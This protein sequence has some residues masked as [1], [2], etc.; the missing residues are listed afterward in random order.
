MY[1]AAKEEEGK[2]HKSF[3]FSSDFFAA[4][5]AVLQLFISPFFDIFLSLCLFLL[6]P[7]RT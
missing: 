1:I 2:L 4:L 3:F 6:L 5:P 7:Q